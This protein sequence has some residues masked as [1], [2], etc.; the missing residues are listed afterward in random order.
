MVI[1]STVITLWGAVKKA[2]HARRGEI[3]SG[4]VLVVRRS[5]QIEAGTQQA[6]F[7]DVPMKYSPLP[8]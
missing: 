4:G 6:D 7:L 5:E 8:I 3:L 1:V 2:S